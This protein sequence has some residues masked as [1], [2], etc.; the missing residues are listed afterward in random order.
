MSHAGLYAIVDPDALGSRD[1]AEFAHAILRGGAAKLQLRA[2]NLPDRARL[3]LAR[4]LRALCREARVP[5]VMNDRPDLALLVGAD[6]LHIGQND[7][8]IAEARRIV[9]NMSIARSSHSLRSALEAVEEGADVVA[10]G[11]IFPTTSKSDADPAVGLEIFTQICQAVSV[12]VTA[13]GGV[14]LEN[15][16]TIRKAGATNAAMIAALVR[17]DDVEATARALHRALGG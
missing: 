6:E 3:S 16:P 8:P 2:K 1:P 5:F 9:G 7:L 4:R 10:V 12:P 17:A 15:A 14:T 13:I 11:P